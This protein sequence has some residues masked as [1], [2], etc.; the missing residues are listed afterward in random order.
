MCYKT[1]PPHSL[2]LSNF[3]IHTCIWWIY[4]IY[5]HMYVYIYICKSYWCVF[6]PQWSL[7]S[8]PWDNRR[9]RT[10]TGSYSHSF[11]IYNATVIKDNSFSD[12]PTE[13]GPMGGQTFFL[14]NVDPKLPINPEGSLR[15]F[16]WLCA[17]LPV[18]ATL[19]ECDRKYP[20]T[21]QSPYFTHM[22][23]SGA[24]LLRH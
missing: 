8:Q 7:S 18:T 15:N 23:R 4:R 21:S 9:K 24:L 3:Y 11:Y 20:G 5:I 14:E 12:R 22:A 13:S 10:T 16:S 2:S 17:W 1:P 6:S 19:T